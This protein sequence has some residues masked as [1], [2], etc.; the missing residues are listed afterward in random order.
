MR[1]H[2]AAI[3]LAVTGRTSVADAVSI[4]TWRVTE[5]RLCTMLGI[6][7]AADAYLKRLRDEIERVDQ[8]AMVRWADLIYQA[9]EKGRIR[10]HHGQWRIGHDGQPHV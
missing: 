10:L 3:V 9:W 8:T 4:G 5:G 2:A 1:R 7:L 6:E